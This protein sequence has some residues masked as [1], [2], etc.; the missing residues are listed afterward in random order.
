MTTP[1]AEPVRPRQGVGLRLLLAQVM[2]LGAGAV[3]AWVVAALVGPPL[4]REHLHRAGVPA[5][6]PEELHAEEAHG[7]AT[8]LS[9]GGA[10][11]VSALTALAVSWYLSRRLQRSVA[12]VASAAEAVAHGRYD[13]RVAPPRLGDEFDALAQAFNEMA[14]RLQAVEATRRQLFGDLAHEIR[15]PVSV[16]EAYM[17]ALED[18][19]RSLTPETTVMLRDQTR[20]LVRF[21]EDFAAL[22]QAEESSA[23]MEFAWVNIGELVN[24]SIAAQRE[25]FRE[26]RVDLIATVSSDEPPV[27]ADPQRLAQVLGNLIE[28]ALR[29]TPP[30]GRVDVSARADHHELT[31]R[32]ADTGEGIPAEHLPHLFERFY[33]VDAARDRDRGGAGIGLAIAKALVEAHGGHITATSDGPG[34][35]TTF[36]ISLP[37]TSSR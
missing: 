19:V 7:Y 36:T 16:L 12:E 23:A 32:V 5:N 37:L 30:G 20:R 9:V 27:W 8:A 18:G 22:A 14:A 31:L 1:Q 6:S 3:T 13:I 2:V 34:M 11:A 28:N 15:T 10:L 29:H 24:N 35:G 33:R 21:S 25:P 17:E 4:F 26:K